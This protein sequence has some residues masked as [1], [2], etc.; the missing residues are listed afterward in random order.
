MIDASSDRC[1]ARLHGIEAIDYFLA[2][3]LLETLGSQDTTLFHLLLA[4][5]WSLRQGHSCLSIQSIAGQQLWDDAESDKPGYPFPQVQQLQD[6]LAQYNL[7]P[8][9]AAPVV[10]EFNHLYLRR[11]RQFEAE[12]ATHLH[13]RIQYQ[14]LSPEQN[15][16]A[17]ATIQQLFPNPPSSNNTAPDWQAVA[18]ANA[19]GRRLSIISGGPG[20]GKTYTVTRVLLTLQAVADGPLRMMMAAP[21]GKAKQRLLESIT[22]AKKALAD[23]GLSQDLLNTLP[24]EASTLHGLL[25][26]RPQ[27]T[28]LRYHRDHLL[29]VDL[30]LVD[31]VSMVDLPMMARI[32]RA[33]PDEAT[34]IL[35][36]DAHQLPS[37]SVGSVL[38]DLVPRQHPGYSNATAD[39]LYQLTGYD[40]PRSDDSASDYSTF[41]AKSHR[42]DG[43]GGIGLLAKD[44]I[45]RQSEPSWASLHTRGAELPHRKPTEQLSYLPPEEVDRWLAQAVERYYQPIAT[46]ADITTA[47]KQLAQF[48]LLVPTRKGPLG[49]EMLNQQIEIQ[50]AR[51]NPRIKPGQHFHG[52]AIM[53]TRN[54]HGLKVYNGDVGLVW[55]N[56]NG[57]LEAHF[58][59]EAAGEQGMQT[60]NLGLLPELE[61]VYAMTIHKTQG[62]EFGHVAL[63]L[64]ESPTRLL[65][66]ELLY[67][68]ITRAKDHCTISASE[69][70]WKNALENRT[71]RN[72]GLAERLA[73]SD[74]KD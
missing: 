22:S 43:K 40:V 28:Q 48:R 39:R 35:V 27:S 24:E 66:A 33:L 8:A 17:Q 44:I 49:V 15:A 4:L 11:Y 74:R 37:I 61:S 9:S 42:F 53:I 5:H 67:T 50:L 72:S 71:E 69:M 51:H 23:A 13:A 34:L 41:L 6:Q 47:F 46:A 30:L 29:P 12:L 10:F 57:K 59:R 20:T 25:G 70:V 52:R 58:E 56:S 26:F 45:N 31:E 73:A 62:S 64:A 63:L 54:H 7:E 21:T 16:T 19:L 65:S 60:I 55:A 2:K 14:A 3:A 36:G 1:M 32:L 18:T 38:S 68:G